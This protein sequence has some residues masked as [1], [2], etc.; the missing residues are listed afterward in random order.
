M[1]IRLRVA[2]SFEEADAFDLDDIENSTAAERML[3]AIHMMTGAQ[4]T[5]R[6]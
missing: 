3:A 5:P 2:R 4:V 1:E 6:R